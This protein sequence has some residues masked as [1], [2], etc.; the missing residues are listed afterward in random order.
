VYGHSVASLDAKRKEAMVQRFYAASTDT[1]TRG[2]ILKT[3]GATIVAVGPREREM[4]FGGDPSLTLMY[5]SEGVDLYRV[6][7]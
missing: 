7:R 2:E 5:S 3:S 4:G 6:L 1:V